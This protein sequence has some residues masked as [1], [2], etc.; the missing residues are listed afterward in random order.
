M[1]IAPRGCRLAGPD[2]A[3]PRTRACPRRRQGGREQCHGTV[4]RGVDNPLARDFPSSQGPLGG[5]MKW[6]TYVV[7]AL[8]LVTARIGVAQETTSAI[9]GRIVDDQGLGL[10]GAAV[11]VTGAQGQRRAVTDVDGVFRVSALTPGTY[12]VQVDLQGFKGLSQDDIALS[13]GQTINLQTL[14]MQ[15]GGLTERV[16]LVADPPVID[17]STTTIGATIDSDLLQRVP[18]GRRFS[19]TIYVAPG[20]SSGG[21]TGEANPSIAGGSGLENQYV[22]DGV[23]ITNAGYGALGSY[24]IIFGSLGN[25]VPFDFLREVQVKTAGF[26]AEHGQATGGVV[27]VITKSGGNGYHGSAFAYV[28]PEAAEGGYTPI[29][30]QSLSREEAVNTTSSSLTDFGIEIGGPIV[31]DRAFFFAALDPQWEGQKRIAPENVPLRE[32][33]EV[34]RERQLTTYAAKATVQAT[35]GHRLDASFFGDPADGR[36]GPQRDEALLRDDTGGFSSLTYGGHSQMVKYEGAP[37]PTWLL[38]ASLSRAQNA[39]EEQPVVDAW[40]V[41]DETVEPF[42]R[43]GGLG[44]VEDN[45]GTNIQYAVKSTHYVGDHEVRYGLSFEDIDYDNVI[46]RT[47]PSFLLP[48]GTETLTGAEVRILPDPVLGQIYRVRRANT[49]TLR[50]TSQQ[51]FSFFAQDSWRVGNRL[52]IQPGIRYEQQTLEGSLSDVTWDANWA[53]RLGVTYDIVGD[54]RSKLFFSW[55]RFFAKIPNDLAARAMGADAGTTRADYF[56]AALTEPIPNGVVA[57]PADDD[58]HFIQAGLAPAEFDSDAKTTFLDEVLVGVE[59]EAW[60][61]VNLT[62]RYVHRSLDRVLE[63]VGTAPMAAYFLFPDVVGNSVEFFVTNPDGQTPVSEFPGITASFESPIHDYDAVELMAAK[64]FSDDW[65][66]QASYRWSRL[67]GTFEGFFRNDN[68]QSDPVITSLFDFPTN[69][70][71]YTEIGVPQFGW[72]GDIRNLGE[73]GAGLLPNDRTHQFK[74]YGNYSFP[75]RLNLGLGLQVGSGRPLTPLA[76][77]PLYESAGEIPE[78]PRGAGFDTQDGF[79]LR[80][81]VV[82]DMGVHADYGLRFGA[83]GITLSVDA[84]NL[85]DLQN[86]LDYDNYTE[87]GPGTLNPDFGSVLAY[88][89]PRQV[90]LGVRF[91]F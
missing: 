30:S 38:E 86:A 25:G 62:A 85:F 90:R 46:D 67:S 72:R 13:L 39:I 4:V 54:G 1:R 74:V 65:A 17:A 80:S 27:N 10:P 88:Q 20:V 3:R 19:D 89:T 57:G 40:D 6:W 8:V 64:R 11:T 78:R 49:S 83:M 45:D 29:V 66:L 42:R 71:S 31:P 22:V 76:A 82:A 81:P 55:G 50:D 52:T 84:F 69:D 51:Y 14:L 24:S 33:G 21:G 87:I 59:Y 16:E 34:E 41:I 9:T 2:P 63:D 15:V 53:P 7:L 79:R 35:N 32:L 70:P 26:E 58:I 48:D 60:P 23:N 56:D 5:P 36:N 18:V 91:T 73:A 43:S 44:F 47:G 28:R 68:G 37:T 77:N 12:S 61:G 75:F